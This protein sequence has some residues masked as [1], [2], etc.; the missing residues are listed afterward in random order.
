MDDP[1]RELN[2][3]ETV[4]NITVAIKKLLP[5]QKFVIMQSMIEKRKL[6]Y[7]ANELG[8]T[9]QAVWKLKKRALVK[10]KKE[11]CNSREPKGSF[12]FYLKNI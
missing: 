2:Q 5:K 11:L 8:I 4:K 6:T 10:L 12:L 1:Q 3:R 9:V 7:I